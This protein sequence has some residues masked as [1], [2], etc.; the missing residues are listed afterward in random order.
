MGL[1]SSKEVPDELNLRHDQF[2]WDEVDPATREPWPEKDRL[3]LLA[4]AKAVDERVTREL[5]ALFPPG[6]SSTDQSKEG[7]KEREEDE[8]NARFCEFMKR[9]I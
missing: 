8:V 5:S 1:T 7:D 2:P 6:E 3:Q 9:I 4:M